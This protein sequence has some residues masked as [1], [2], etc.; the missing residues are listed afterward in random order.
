MNHGTETA[1]AC[2][3]YLGCLLK[4]GT[5]AVIQSLAI[6]AFDG[7]TA[8]ELTLV[9][10]NLFVK[11]DAERDAWEAESESSRGRLEVMMRREADV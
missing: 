3:F 4:E 1:F 7:F 6:V 9:C 10:N 11:M 5:D 8:S 2:I